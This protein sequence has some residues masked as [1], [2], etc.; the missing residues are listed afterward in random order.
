MHLSALLSS[1]SLHFA[2]SPKGLGTARRGF[3]AWLP[4]EEKGEE[5]NEKGKKWSVREKEGAWGG[6]EGVGWMGLAPLWMGL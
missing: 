1:S 2:S 6:R 5:G 3:G 4:W